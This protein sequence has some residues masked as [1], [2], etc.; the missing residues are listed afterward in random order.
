M[1]T[2]SGLEILS[3]EDS[4]SASSPDVSVA[5]AV[6]DGGSLEVSSEALGA[7]EGR[8]AQA[9]DGAVREV[10]VLQVSQEALGALD[11]GSAQVVGLTSS[12]TE[13]LDDAVAVASPPTEAGSD[14]RVEGGEA[15]E[16]PSDS[17]LN[18]DA[19]SDLTRG[20]VSEE[21]LPSSERAAE[22]SPSSTTSEVSETPWSVGDASARIEPAPSDESTSRETVAT[23][24]EFEP[25]SANEA[26]AT[27]RASQL[28]EGEGTA[29]TT[30][31]PALAQVEEHAAPT[32]KDETAPQATSSA[33]GDAE[34]VRLSTREEVEERAAVAPSTAGSEATALDGP[35][36]TGAE[37][38]SD[39][40]LASVIAS[41]P[42]SIESQTAHGS[43]LPTVDVDSGVEASHR[44]PSVSDARST[45]QDASPLDDWGDVAQSESK[46]TGDSEDAEPI[47]REVRST[48]A[49]A[50]ESSVE[51]S[52]ASTQSD[53]STE[54]EVSPASTTESAAR[55]LQT[56]A[57][58]NDARGTRNEEP[59]SAPEVQSSTAVA[60][61][62]ESEVK[63]HAELPASTEVPAPE[64]SGASTSDSTEAP[65]VE[66]WKLMKATLGD[67]SQVDQDTSS[68]AID[69]S[70]PAAVPV[71]GDVGE[72][73]TIEAAG[74]MLASHGEPSGSATV[75]SPP[76]ESPSP[77]DA[78]P[79]AHAGAEVI[80][81]REPQVPDAE[82]TP[83]EPSPRPVPP[84]RAAI[85][86][87]ELPA[88]D[89]APMQLASTWEF[90]GW[91]GAEGNGTIGHSAESTWEDRAV[92]LEGNARAAAPAG[93][94]TEL[95][96][97]SAWD[98]IQQPWQPQARAPS[99]A[100]ATLLAA[101]DES[102]PDA[103]H[104]GPKVS[105][106][107]VLTALDDVGSQGVLGKVLIAY[108]AGRFQRAFLL[109]ESFGL[110]RVGHAWGPGSDS[111][112]V[113]SLKVDLE[114]PSLLVSALGQLGPSSFDAP[115]CVQDE[116]IFAAL[117]GPTSHLLVV[118][119][120]ARGRPVAFVVADSGGAHVATTTLDEL[121][122]VSAKA[123]EVY[124]RLPATRAE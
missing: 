103:S 78:A 113:A 64:H 2:E 107:Q 73:L 72:T 23:T 50:S 76:V 71:E 22:E 59:S 33:P 60:Y 90:V 110:V 88:A 83:T 48:E 10:G 38:V 49:A 28:L 15:Q 80:A 17:S 68:P 12:N 92:D 74:T 52:S 1:E 20:N 47:A 16:R 84:R 87:D 85:E 116:A 24:P 18:V 109:G 96:L 42:F 45:G 102:T 121:T 7:S 115:S 100:L 112:A 25:A 99:E 55:E 9:T 26:G 8:E 75:A 11:D 29:A 117:G 119:I 35:A 63:P 21:G 86:L 31:V 32:D 27:S 34:V 36:P 4:A 101:A 89:D 120:R 39:V 81:L 53:V 13:R 40:A 114:A 82:P 106:D 97:A 5:D 57:L 105:A 77:V 104:D 94:T 19:A 56:A 65:S 30:D 95:P 43:S 93:A 14:A 124:D 54:A 6:L 123:S 51:L 37:T 46:V 122:R 111:P 67:A 108:C 70:A 66:H 69:S 41:A 44:Q 61:L 3:T 98:F 79:V 91:Q 118:P 58:S 62:D